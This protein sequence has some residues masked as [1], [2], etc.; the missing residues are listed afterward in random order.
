[1]QGTRSEG[2][3]AQG[4]PAA[5]D[6]SH[7]NKNSNSGSPGKKQKKQPKTTTTKTTQ[8]L[9]EYYLLTGTV[10]GVPGTVPQYGVL[11]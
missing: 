9:R 10:M 1:V 8:P 5:N 6:N 4:A 11:G 2:G 7:K 3:G